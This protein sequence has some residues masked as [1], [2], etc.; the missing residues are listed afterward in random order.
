MTVFDWHE[1]TKKQWNQSAS[2]WNARSKNMWEHGSRKGIIPFITAHADAA[3][4]A[5]DIGCG[6]GYGTHK[7]AKAGFDVVGVDLSSE[8]ISLANSHTHDSNIR[9]VEADARN[10]PFENGEFACIMAINVLEWTENPKKVLAEWLR[11]LQKDGL[12]FVGLLG[13]TAGP[14]ANSYPRLH[15]K[16]ALCNTMMPWEF[17]QLAG[18]M[19]LTLVDEFGVYKKEVKKEQH[20]SLPI[21]LKQAL[22]FMWVFCLRK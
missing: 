14:R 16:P 18:E 8:M 3:K 7:L 12:L 22:S 20:Q 10:L 13:P 15:G 9:F 21:Q 19:G 6:D 2:F 5:L 11:V 17:Q 4:P 1:A